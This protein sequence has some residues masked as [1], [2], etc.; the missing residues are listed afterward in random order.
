[1]TIYFTVIV[2]GNECTKDFSKSRTDLE[3]SSLAV[4]PGGEPLE[5]RH[6]PEMVLVQ[7]LPQVCRLHKGLHQV[8][9]LVNLVCL[10]LHTMTIHLS[11]FHVCA[12]FPMH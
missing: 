9:P 2:D 4:E 7:V 11:I 5:V 12:N 6:L 8:Q 10:W 3:R 1:M